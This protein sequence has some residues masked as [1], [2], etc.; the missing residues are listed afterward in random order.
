MNRV[1]V[2]GGGLAGSEAAWQLA[3]RGVAVRLIEQKPVR[4]SPAHQ[5]PGLGE[6]VC[7]NS[8]KSKDPESMPGLLKDEMRRLGSLI[9]AAAD[10]S[11]VAAGQALAVDRD[12]FS[13]F[14]TDRLTA[15][16]QVAVERAEAAALP[17]ESEGLA[18]IATGPL[19]SDAL[20]RA[21]AERIGET[22][23][24]FYDSIAPIVDAGSINRDI[25]FTASRY[26]KGS[27]EQGDYLNCPLSREEY[28][29][30]V[31]E[32]LAARK[33]TPREFE[34]AKYFEGC[35]PI[36]VM[37]E[38]GERTLAFGPMKP[39]GLIDPRTG[40]RPHAVVQLRRENREGTSFNLVGF[41]T[42]LAWPE[43]SRIFRMVPGL[44]NAEFLR[45]G[46][47]HRNT[48][49]DSPRLLGPT[50]ELKAAPWIRLAGQI[51]GVEG[52]TESSAIGLL[53][54]LFAAAR[55]SGKNLPPP[56]PE[57]ALGALCRYLRE[58]ASN[59]PFDPMNIHAGL[60]PAP[61]ADIHKSERK[62]FIARRA[63][64][65]LEEWLQTSPFPVM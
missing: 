38:R 40:R 24:Y 61:P 58:G 50:L 41:Q 8:L 52:Y 13:A 29:A 30:F 34:D 39:V 16:P 37:A 25:A 36:E 18:I 60:F 7:S 65:S 11:A 51:T 19:T 56:P 9:I 5:S 43:Q 12:R 42:R 4:F 48:Y 3:R 44:E 33:V 26:D 20:A 31:R 2:I 17:Q 1:T 57:T 28:E 45:F 55:L 64:E 53:A 59:R 14:I 23:L 49:L 63:R 15:Q 62:S 54:G 21:L 35:L 10:E 46:S 47:I 32:L 27:E 22:R 6:L